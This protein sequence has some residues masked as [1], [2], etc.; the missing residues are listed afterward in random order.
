MKILKVKSENEN[1]TKLL[2]RVK[3]GCKPDYSLNAFDS[4]S[5]ST[6]PDPFPGLHYS[7]VELKRDH[8]VD[9]A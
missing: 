1:N 9:G 6:Q 5:Y 7:E 8:G 2:K 3:N 4:T